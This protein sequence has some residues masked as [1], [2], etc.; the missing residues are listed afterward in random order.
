MHNPHKITRK[1]APAL[2]DLT[3]SRRAKQQQPRKSFVIAVIRSHNSSG[4]S[5]QTLDQVY[6][7]TYY[8][9][10]PT[11][12]TQFLLF[13][14]NPALNLIPARV[15]TF[16]QLGLKV[17]LSYRSRTVRATPIFLS[18]FP[19]KKLNSNRSRFLLPGPNPRA[20]SNTYILINPSLQWQEE[21]VSAS[22][23][24]A[25]TS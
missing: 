6:D 14:A 13:V 24:T 20:L 8:Y 9:P 1:I 22:N 16:S 21:F 19:C 17:R 3:V 4:A 18:S 15:S 25:A 23:P 12:S 2:P 10:K 7:C 11:P 5:S